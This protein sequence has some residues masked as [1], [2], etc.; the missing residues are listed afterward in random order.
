MGYTGNDIPMERQ[1]FGKLTVVCQEGKTP[2][3]EY[4]W[5]C[6]CSCGGGAER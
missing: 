2:S 1:V 5:R 4:M 6:N 3:R